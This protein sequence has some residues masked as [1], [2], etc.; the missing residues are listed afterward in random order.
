[1]STVTRT[2]KLFSRKIRIS[3]I[4][5]KKKPVLDVKNLKNPFEM[6]DELQREIIRRN[7]KASDIADPYLYVRNLY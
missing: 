4:T 5:P 7:I 3:I 2:F 6:T 1:M